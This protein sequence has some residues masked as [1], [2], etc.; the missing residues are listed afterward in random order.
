MEDVAHGGAAANDIVELVA[1]VQFFAH[2]LVFGAQRLHG[3]H[4]VHQRGQMVERKGLLQKIGGPSF[5]ASTAVS[6]EPCAVM[7]I[8]AA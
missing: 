7:T 5:M 1:M 4:F 3:H 8:T 6:T 2:A